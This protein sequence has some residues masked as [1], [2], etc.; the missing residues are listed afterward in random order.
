[1]HKIGKSYRQIPRYLSSS[2]FHL[3]FFIFVL[4]WRKRWMICFI[5]VSSY[6]FCSQ[7]FLSTWQKL[8]FN[9]LKRKRCR[10]NFELIFVD[11]TGQ[12][13]FKGRSGSTTTTN[14]D[15]TAKATDASTFHV[16][17]IE[18]S[19]ASIYGW[20]GHWQRFRLDDRSRTDSKESSRVYY[21]DC[22]RRR[23]LRN[24][25]VGQCWAGK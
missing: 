6:K 12:F 23:R 24:P 17:T 3:R 21:T 9:I 8:K 14:I 1:M 22:C 13:W 4:S 19:V 18:F 7:N 15:S 5:F 25:E 11:I 10:K 2:V 16:P 20:F